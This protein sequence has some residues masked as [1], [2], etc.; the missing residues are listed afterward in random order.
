MS[1]SNGAKRSGRRRDSSPAHFAALIQEMLDRRLT[2][3]STS[4]CLY[5]KEA[6]YRRCVRSSLD[7]WCHKE[8]VGRPEHPLSADTHPSEV[9]MLG[10][11]WTWAGVGGAI[12]VSSKVDGTLD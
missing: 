6:M 10:G 8:R 11:R 5:V 7:C 9:L 12:T 4:R 2:T 1:S 3:T